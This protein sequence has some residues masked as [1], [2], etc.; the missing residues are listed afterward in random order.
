MKYLLLKCGII[1]AI[2]LMREFTQI[3]GDAL[4]ILNKANLTVYWKR[5][6]ECIPMCYATHCTRHICTVN[7]QVHHAGWKIHIRQKW[8]RTKYFVTFVIKWLYKG[9]NWLTS[10]A[11]QLF[12]FTM[13]PF[14]IWNFHINWYYSMIN[15]IDIIRFK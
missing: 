7:I 10:L 12:H 4:T 13:N 14:W 6:Q 15:D 3:H 8:L 5:K 9:R 1:Q 11:Y 2:K